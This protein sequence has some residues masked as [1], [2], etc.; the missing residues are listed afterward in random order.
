MLVLK[1]KEGV[2]KGNRVNE[3]RK[4]KKHTDDWDVVEK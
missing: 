4:K 2:F 3:R 1:G